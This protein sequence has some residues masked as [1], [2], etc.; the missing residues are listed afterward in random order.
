VTN[1]R[2][3]VRPWLADCPDFLLLFAFKII[4]NAFL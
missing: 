1:V 4:S 2:M 3:Q